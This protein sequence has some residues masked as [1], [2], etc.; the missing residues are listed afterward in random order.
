M[1]D[2]VAVDGA[3]VKDQTI[4]Y[5]STLSQS[6]RRL[7]FGDYSYFVHRSVQYIVFNNRLFSF[8]HLFSGHLLK[9]SQV[10]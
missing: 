4:G 3:D 2:L 8:S 1:I 5:F 6:F 10:S 9:L 7:V